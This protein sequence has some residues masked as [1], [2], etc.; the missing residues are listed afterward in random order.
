MQ[1]R[2]LVR[3]VAFPDDLAG[4]VDDLQLRALG[5]GGQFVAP[6]RLA[7][8]QGGGGPG[9]GH[10]FA[11]IVGGVVQAAPRLGG[12]QAFQQVVGQQLLLDARHLGQLGRELI[13]IQRRQRVLVLHLGGQQGQKGLEVRGHHRLAAVQAALGVDGRDRGGHVSDPHI[14]AVARLGMVGPGARRRRDGEIGLGGQP[15]GAGE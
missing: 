8:V 15:G 1:A 12:D 11:N 10:L 5:V 4:A 6:S 9:G 13:G 7:F 3:G 14:D 2:R